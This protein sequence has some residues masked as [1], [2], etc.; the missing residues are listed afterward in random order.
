MA[1]DLVVQQKTFLQYL[2][3]Y[4]KRIAA[5]LPATVSKYLT[6]ERMMSICGQAVSRNPDLLGCNP[7]SVVNAIVH[8]AQVGLEPR[9]REAYLIPFG[10]ECVP[11][12]DYRGMVYLARRS[13]LVK[14][15]AANA[16]YQGDEF[17]YDLG[18]K[19]FLH[20]KPATWKDENGKRLPLDMEERGALIA[21][22]CVPFWIDGSPASPT[23][24]SVLAIDRIRGKSR[25]SGKGPW[26]SDYDQMAI[27]SAV[28][29]GM[30]LMP[31]GGET[32][33]RQAQD[34]EEAA[35][36]GP[37]PNLM[38]FVDVTPET[39]SAA[40]NGDSKGD[41]KSKA[42]AKAEEGRHTEDL[43]AAREVAGDER[44]FAVLGSH[45]FERAEEVPSSKAQDII[46]ELLSQTTAAH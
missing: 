39:V 18:S 11:I 7:L 12:I 21:T 35:E 15:V 29:V 32:Q 44:F 25:A 36:T 38:E 42:K 4:E 17:D 22:W 19:P 31:Q 13:G 43:K 26:V 3:A 20:H 40:P 30:N 24:L 9:P 34:M 6:I 5:S 27:K 1:N 2:Q 46:K 16:V 14:D 28:R 41:L 23:V 33:Y 8:L 10:K 37:L 45:G